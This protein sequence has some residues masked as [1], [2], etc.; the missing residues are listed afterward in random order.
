[1]LKI[2]FEI[3]SLVKKTYC[4]TKVTDI[5]NQLN[6]HNHDK[7]I[8][9]Q[10]SKKLEADVFNARLGQAKMITKT[11]FDAKLLSLNRKI[12]VN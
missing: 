6:N 11:D 8:D 3:S 9:T 12:A 4:N 1:M 7:Y 2:K 10:E 5:K